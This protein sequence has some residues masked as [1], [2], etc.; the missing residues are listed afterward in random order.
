MKQ[1][2]LSDDETESGSTSSELRVEGKGR[3]VRGLRSRQKRQ[4][5][6]VVDSKMDGS[7]SSFLEIS[8]IGQRARENYKRQLDGFLNFVSKN[9]L[10][11]RTDAQM[12][13]ALV[14][15][16]NAKF[17]EGEG[18]YVGDYVLASLLDRHPEFG[19]YG[20]RKIPRAWRCI[21]GWR[22]LSP[23]RARLAFPFPVWAAVSWRM[24]ARGHVQKAIFNLV[25][26]CT[27]LRPG[28]LLKLRKMG[29]V[30][31]T[32]GI[33]NFWSVVTSLTETSDVSKT[34]SKDDS[35]MLDSQWIQ[36][37]HPLLEVI[38]KGKP[39]DLVWKFTYNEYVSVFQ[40]C[41]L[42]LRLTLVP[43]QARHPALR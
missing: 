12:D 33:T 6:K 1:Q 11:T 9:G 22:K 8:A 20:H 28:S 23:T 41:C 3:R 27:Y 25:Q 32:G 4:L 30:R 14:K 42:D 24:V 17:A 16:F 2:N 31:P 10:E 38:S 21:K 39:M 5:K 26:L 36:F 7:S 34:N 18:S 15:Y 29:L 13:L 43:Y 35:V 40:S 19:R 37:M